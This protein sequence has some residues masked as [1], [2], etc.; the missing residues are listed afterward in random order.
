[1]DQERSFDERTN[2]RR[3]FEKAQLQ[4]KK[5]V[6]EVSWLKSQ[7]ADQKQKLRAANEENDSLQEK[8][9]ELKGNYM[10]NNQ[11]DGLDADDP[12]GGLQ[13]FERN[14]MQQAI[15]ELSDR[16]RKLRDENKKLDSENNFFHVSTAIFIKLKP[17]ME[18]EKQ[19]CR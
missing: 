12:N 9:L 10:Q 8:L 15:D 14:R 16:C 7:V 11:S 13:D 3:D 19:L 2:L 5:A 1:M 6:D 17:I 4:E 18:T